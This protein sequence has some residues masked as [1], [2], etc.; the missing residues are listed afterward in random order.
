V[1]P[2][3]LQARPGRFACRMPL[4]MVVSPPAIASLISRNLVPVAGVL[5]LGWSAANLLL[6]YYIDTVLEF[7]VV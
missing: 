7:A 6:L 2:V 3:L 5:F 4:A 1:T